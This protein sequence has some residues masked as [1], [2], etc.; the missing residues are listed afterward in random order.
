MIDLHS[1]ILP[2]I[3]DGAADLDE[4]IA[5]CRMA[6]RDGIRTIVATPHIGKFPNTR[7]I[8][9]KKAEELRRVMRSQGIDL[10]LFI[11]ADY[12]FSPEIFSRIQN[13]ALLTINSSR[14]LLLDIP[15]SLMPPNV[16]RHIERMVNAGIVPIIT[17]PERCL[18]VQ[19]EVAILDDIVKAGALV[20]LTASSIMGRMGTRARETAHL[21][22]KK[23]LAHVIATDAHGLSKRPPILSEAVALASGI[24]GKDRALAMVT[25]TPQQIIGN[26]ST[27][28]FSS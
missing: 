11:G 13:K 5:M 27:P 8:I 24:I 14:Y 1:H 20:Q 19:E 25:S 15:Y 28:A 10:A 3:D 4:S 21:I 23:N 2:G 12:E 9:E 17:H 26:A 6:F 22:L 7:E 16:P 18:Q